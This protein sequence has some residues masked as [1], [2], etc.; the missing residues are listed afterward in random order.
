MILKVCV[1]SVT[2]STTDLLIT[3]CPNINPKKLGDF[4]VTG[5]EEDL[6]TF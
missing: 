1:C 6:I 4:P 2:I 5:N 3:S